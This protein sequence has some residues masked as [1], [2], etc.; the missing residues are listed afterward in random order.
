M[1]WA[2][3]IWQLVPCSRLKQVGRQKHCPPLLVPQG[4]KKVLL[5]PPAIWLAAARA[6][7]SHRIY[8]K[9]GSIV[10]MSVPIH[11]KQP[12]KS[13]YGSFIY[14]MTRRLD[15]RGVADK[16]EIVPGGHSRHGLKQQ[17]RNRSAM[18]IT[19]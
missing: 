4:A 1:D 17:Q 13:T 15:T 16:E 18:E 5:G 7:G 8:G 6:H 10:R 2:R 9:E 11:G 19:A 12:L 14:K 3:F